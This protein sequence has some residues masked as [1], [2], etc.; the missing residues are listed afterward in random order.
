MSD[1]REPVFRFLPGEELLHIIGSPGPDTDPC[2]MVEDDGGGTVTIKFQ[3]HGKGPFHT[4]D[5]PRDQIMWKRGSDTAKRFSRWKVE[6][7]SFPMP[8]YISVSGW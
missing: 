6:N 7:E 5:R 8:P 4:V 1:L 2:I 3:V